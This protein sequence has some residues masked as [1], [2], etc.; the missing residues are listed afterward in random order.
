MNNVKN[1]LQDIIVLIQVE[2]VQNALN[3]V[4][5]IKIKLKINKAI[6]RGFLIIKFQQKNV[7]YKIY[8]LEHKIF[9]I[10]FQIINNVKKDIPEPYAQ[11]VIQKESS[12]LL[13]IIIQID[14][15]VNLVIE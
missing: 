15:P 4:F 11:I 12:G 7:A 5:A 1:A 2:N 3:F 13:N 10:I 9:L 8:V 14:L 6:G